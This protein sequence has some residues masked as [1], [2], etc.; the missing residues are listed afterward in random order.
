MSSF[1]C[2]TK[3][4]QAEYCGQDIHWDIVRLEE[5]L[6]VDEAEYEENEN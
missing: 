4:V 5:F 1:T 6:A 2:Y 3:V